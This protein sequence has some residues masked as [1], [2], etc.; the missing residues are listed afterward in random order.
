M[1]VGWIGCRQYAQ[2][3]QGPCGRKD[4]GILMDG[5]ETGEAELQ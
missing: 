4:L 5:K 1:K 3:V 2:C